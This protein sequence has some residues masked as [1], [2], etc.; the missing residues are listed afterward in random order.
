ML[1]CKNCNYHILE[2]D[3]D[4]NVVETIHKDNEVIIYVDCPN[5]GTTNEIHYKL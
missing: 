5:C 4:A 1:F 2:E 3:F